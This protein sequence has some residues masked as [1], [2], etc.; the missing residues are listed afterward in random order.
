MGHDAAPTSCSC[1]SMLLQCPR[2]SKLHAILQSVQEIR[3]QQRGAGWI[4]I[5]VYRNQQGCR[6]WRHSGG[7]GR[8][9]AADALGG[10]RGSGGV[11]GGQPDRTVPVVRA[12]DDEPGD[13]RRR[14]A[15]R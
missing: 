5:Q 11:P 9:S 6:T 8:G 1:K 14:R 13:P 2:V 15:R 4:Q 10:A 12:P 3:N 7:R